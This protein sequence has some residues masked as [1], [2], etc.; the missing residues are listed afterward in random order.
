MSSQD[1]ERMAIIVSESASQGAAVKDGF[2][3]SE[4]QAQ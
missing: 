1:I 2:T 3:I 4:R